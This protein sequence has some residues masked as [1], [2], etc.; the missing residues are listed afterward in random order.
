M[1]IALGLAGVCF[2]LMKAIE[3]V[4]RKSIGSRLEAG[5][6]RFRDEEYDE[7]GNVRD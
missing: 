3:F 5:I 7:Y 6:N 1:I 4:E 2:V